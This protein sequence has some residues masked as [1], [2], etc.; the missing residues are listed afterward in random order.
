MYWVFPHLTTPCYLFTFFFGTN[1]FVIELKTKSKADTLILAKVPPKKTL[2]ETVNEVRQR[3]EQATSNPFEFR[4]L[5][6]PKTDFTLTRTYGE[7][8]GRHLALKKTARWSGYF[9][10]DAKQIIRFRLDERGALLKSEAQFSLA[11]GPPPEPVDLVFDQPFLV[12]L[13]R[14]GVRTPYFALWIDNAE[15]LVP[16]N[17]GLAAP[18][19]TEGGR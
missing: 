11:S 3:I 5:L 4:W 1:D 19:V 12:L 6:V 15:L 10:L 7:L 14:V 9:V 13:Q 2:T 16:W 18:V 17:S 8:V